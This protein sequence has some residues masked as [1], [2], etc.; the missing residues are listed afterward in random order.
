MEG[1]ETSFDVSGLRLAAASW[2]KCL[3]VLM[4]GLLVQCGPGWWKPAGGIWD[5]KWARDDMGD[6]VNM[7]TC[8]PT[9]SFVCNTGQA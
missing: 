4:E 1:V 9:L 6:L 7:S 2:P 3:P 5:S 8:T